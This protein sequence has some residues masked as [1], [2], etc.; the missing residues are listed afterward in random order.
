MGGIEVDSNN[1]YP[2]RNRFWGLSQVELHP[3]GTERTSGDRMNFVMLF[4]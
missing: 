1:H 3:C 2:V 4:R